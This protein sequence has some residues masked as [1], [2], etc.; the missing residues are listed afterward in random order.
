M[1][2]ELK[3]LCE[4]ATENTFVQMVLAPHLKPF[5]VY[6]RPLPL[7][8]GN[9]GVVAFGRLRNAVQSEVGRLKPHQYVTTMIDLYGMRNFPGD[10]PGK[11]DV[12]QRVR[13]I[14]AAMAT[15]FNNPQ[16]IPYIQVHE[17]EALVFTDLKFLEGQYP[18]GNVAK[19][20]EQL[21]ADVGDLAPELIND[22]P[23]TAPSKRLQRYLGEY[24]KVVDG[25][26]IAGKIGLAR[27]RLACP[28]FDAWLS[29]LESLAT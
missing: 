14:E 2:V 20:V 28:H 3:I 13:S 15:E 6:S 21:R 24:N 4:G 19:A 10:P 7:C 17:F 18:D 25:P 27:L 12:Y 29:R 8:H 22:G 5:G 11:S 16:V 1:T 9:Y 23:N 26:A